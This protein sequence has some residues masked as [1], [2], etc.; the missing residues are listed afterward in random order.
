MNEKMLRIS[1]CQQNQDE[2][3]GVY[4]I[5]SIKKNEN[6]QLKSKKSKKEYVLEIINEKTIKVVRIVY[7]TH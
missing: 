4:C 3:L 7:A 1:I 6:I 2:D 5:D